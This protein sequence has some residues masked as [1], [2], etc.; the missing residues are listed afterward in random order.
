MA[1]LS[2]RID[3]SNAALVTAQSQIAANIT[4]LAAIDP[5]PGELAAII[6]SL[7]TIQ[8]NLGN[9]KVSPYYP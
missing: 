4:A 7:T 8:A 9:C 1:T 2:D 6:A 5:Q 3:S